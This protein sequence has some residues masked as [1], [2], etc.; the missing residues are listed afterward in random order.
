MTPGIGALARNAIGRLIQMIAV[1]DDFRSATGPYGEAR[2]HYYWQ[3][4]ATN[5]IHEALASVMLR[6]LGCRSF[7]S[8]ERSIA[9]PPPEWTPLEPAS[10]RT[11]RPSKICFEH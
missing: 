5:T 8:L 3:T 9:L 4:M 6:S 10:Q 7:A 2:Q 1:F 11:M